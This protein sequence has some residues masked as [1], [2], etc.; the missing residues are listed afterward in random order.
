[1]FE[2]IGEN[3]EFG[4][5]QRRCGAEPL[6][7]FRFS[8]APFPKLVKALRARFEGLGKPN[9]L[10]I[11]VSDN[12]REYMVLDKC[13]GFLFHAW[14]LVGEMEPS[15]I[16]ARE[17]RR[18]PLLIRKLIEEMTLGDKLFVFHG[19][20]PLTLEEARELAA[21]LRDYGPATLL[22]TELA[23]D[24]HAPGTVEF[25]EPGLLKGHMDRFAPGEN[26]HD[27]SLDCWVTLCKN[28]VQTRHSVPQTPAVA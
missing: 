12:G 7:L 26:A 10:E 17:T 16:A 22:W 2:S 19:M 21:A 24:D 6:G 5:V 11:Q 13:F 1:M 4:L 28:A 15:E 3:C 18:L 20:T 14:V 8:S 23:D 25:I 9:N 27:L